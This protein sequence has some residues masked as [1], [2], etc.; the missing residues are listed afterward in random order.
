MSNTQPK[1]IAYLFGGPSAEHAVSC[2]AAEGTL[3]SFESEFIIKPIFITKEN[4]WVAAESYHPAAEAWDVAQ[5]LMSE[6]GITFDIVLQKLQEDDIYV[7]FIGLHGEFGED[8]TLQALL[9]AHGL[10]YAGSDAAASALAIDKPRVLQLLQNEDILVPEFLELRKEDGGLEWDAFAEYVGYPIVVLPADNG[11]SVGVT[12][13]ENKDV[14]ITVINDLLIK[15]DRIMLSQYIA[16]PEFSCG[17]LATGATELTPLPPTEIQL[18]ND[19]RFWDYDAKYI[20]GECEEIT[21]ANRPEELIE[22]IQALAKRVHLLVGADGFSRTDMI[23]NDKNELVVLE[24]NTLPGMTPQSVLP[25]E[26]KAYG[27]SFGQLLTTICH[28]VDRTEKDYLTFGAE[29]TAADV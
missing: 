6:K 15:Y 2:M 22:Q 21:P 20:A 16:G 5:K 14:L 10:L 3:T 23:L 25:A 7:V 27:L 11:S 4:K 26:A 24:I 19:H 12:I 17:V 13:A 8:G 9:E 1:K 28:N 18:I 29:D